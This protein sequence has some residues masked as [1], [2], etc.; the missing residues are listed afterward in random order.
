MEK[1]AEPEVNCVRF[2]SMAIQINVSSKHSEHRGS[3]N[4]NVRIKLVLNKSLDHHD[5][6][7]ASSYIFPNALT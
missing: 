7:R 4:S 2:I 1:Q 6:G 5:S 3:N